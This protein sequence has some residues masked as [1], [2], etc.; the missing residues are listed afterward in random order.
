MATIT[1][2]QVA[3][4]A[5]VSQST[6]SR[7]LNGGAVSRSTRTRVERAADALGYRPSYAARA[8]STRR[9]G[10]AVALVATLARRSFAEELRGFVAAAGSHTAVTLVDLSTHDAVLRETAHVADRG[11]F[12]GRVVI[13]RAALDTQVTPPAEDM[14]T[15]WVGEDECRGHGDP[16][17]IAVERLE[18]AGRERIHFVAVERSDPAW[19]EY[20]DRRRQ[21]FAELSRDA[22]GRFVMSA[23]A[24]F[25]G[26]F[27]AGAQA[28]ADTGGAPLAVI[29][30]TAEI[31]AGVAVAAGRMGLVFGDGVALISLEDHPLCRLLGVNAVD[32]RSFERGAAA[33]RRLLAE[34]GDTEPAGPSAEAPLTPRLRLRS[35]LAAL[36]VGR[37][38]PSH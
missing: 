6:V 32:V 25:Q 9:A 11:R 8:L 37:P 19:A 28:F 27:D 2:T 20:D 30:G 38:H 1:I 24:T 7:A 33:A 29:A 18:A 14:P 21:T 17:R 36:A 12:D 13:G 35:N 3:S 22:P 4:A 5:G 15:A 16:V 31:A 26:G 10:A 23:P 34:S